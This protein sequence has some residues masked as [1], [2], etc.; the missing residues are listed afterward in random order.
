MPRSGLLD[1]L[2][3]LASEHAEAS[4]RGVEVERVRDERGAAV[5]GRRAVLKSIGA[6][7]GAALASRARFVRAGTTPRIA[8]VG[9]G[10]AGLNA[11]L[12]LADAGYPSTVYEASQRIGGRMHSNRTTWTSGNTSEWCG[13][14]IDSWHHT[15]FRL[16]QRFGLTVVDHIRAQPRGS[17]DTLYL[18]GG[19]YD[20]KQADRD[21]APVHRALADQLR[22][23]P[24]PSCY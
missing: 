20:P 13:E 6:A 1:A 7:A 10:I 11:A 14:L 9:G 3:R 24:F 15:M 4:A 16:A 21:F 18:L 23:A 22:A 8:I 5:V 2:R 19:Y 17:F 12:T